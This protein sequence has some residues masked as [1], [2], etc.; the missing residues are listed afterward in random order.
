MTINNFVEN[1]FS[2]IDSFIFINSLSSSKN[3][4]LGNWNVDRRI[5]KMDPRSKA[6]S[7]KTG[8][9]WKPPVKRNVQFRSKISS[10]PIIINSKNLANLPYILDS[11]IIETK[12]KLE[13]IYL[14]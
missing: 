2:R 14:D 5:L 11:S 4:S 3:R 1:N 12:K 10:I 7:K 6:A 13:E 8:R 9:L